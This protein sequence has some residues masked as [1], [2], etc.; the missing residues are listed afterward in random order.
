MSMRTSQSTLFGVSEGLP[1]GHGIVLQTGVTRRMTL[2]VALVCHESALLRMVAARPMPA[3]LAAVGG[4]ADEQNRWLW[5][6][7]QPLQSNARSLKPLAGATGGPRRSS[8]RGR[9]VSPS[10]S[11]VAHLVQSIAA[12]DGG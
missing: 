2:G 8:A 3:G 10:L 11:M 4:G 1:D 9:M 7:K 5:A 6:L 12:I